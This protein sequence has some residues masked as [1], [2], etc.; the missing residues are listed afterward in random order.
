MIGSRNNLIGIAIGF[1][2]RIIGE[3]ES[4][5]DNFEY[6]YESGISIIV[7]PKGTSPPL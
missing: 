3:E 2:P 5:E 6:S 1:N 4:H 7:I